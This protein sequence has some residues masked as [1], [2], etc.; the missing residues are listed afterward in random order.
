MAAATLV[1]IKLLSG[2]ATHAGLATGGADRAVLAQVAGVPAAAF[3][4]AGAGAPYKLPQPIN[5]PITA[6]GKPRIVY[7]GAEY[8]PFCAVERWPVIVALS[9]FGAWHGLK[10]AYSAAAPEVY[11]DTATFTFHGASYTSDW[12]SFTG[13]ETHTN[14]RLGSGYQVLD[15]P[16]PTDLAILQKYDSG[17]MT[18]FIDLGGRYLI[19]GATYDPTLIV[20]RTQAEIA[21]ALHDPANPT[22]AGIVAA[23]NVITAAICKATGG[24]P[25]SV[26]ASAGVTAAASVLP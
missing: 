15:K 11:P 16:S 1:A 2:S 17:G 22:G 26:C 7:V 19:V 3:D 9:R 24:H 18:P 5:D 23:A 20:G 4:A 14:E 6:D 8:C 25:A 21:T 13:V 12:L 10:Y